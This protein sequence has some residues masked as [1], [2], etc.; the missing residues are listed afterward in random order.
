M[1]KCIKCGRELI[2][3]EIPEFYKSMREMLKLKG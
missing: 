1:R 2:S 3:A